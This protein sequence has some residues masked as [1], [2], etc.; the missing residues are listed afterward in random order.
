MIGIKKPFIEKL[1]KTSECHERFSF[2]KRMLNLHKKRIK[3][4]KEI[5]LF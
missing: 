1:S 5:A 2:K 3:R 4:I